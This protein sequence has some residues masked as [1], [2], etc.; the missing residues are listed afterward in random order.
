MNEQIKKLAKRSYDQA[1][2]KCKKV[3]HTVTE[4]DPI[5]V[6]YCMNEMYKVMIEECIQTLIDN[7]YDDAAN[8]LTKELINV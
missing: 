2:D 4:T 5:L 8:C 1:F 3:E 6:A 7:G